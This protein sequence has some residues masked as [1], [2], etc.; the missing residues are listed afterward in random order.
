MGYAHAK[1][2]TVAH[3]PGGRHA[4]AARQARPRRPHRLS[5]CGHPFFTPR[6]FDAPLRRLAAT[7]RSLLRPWPPSGAFKRATQSIPS[8][9]PLLPASPD[10]GLRP[11]ARSEQ[12]IVVGNLVPALL[13]SL[14]HL[15]E[16]HLLGVGVARQLDV[17]RLERVECQVDVEVPLVV[18]AHRLR[19]EGYDQ[20]ARARAVG[21]P[22]AQQGPDA[23]D[24][25]PAS[26]AARG[27][28]LD[29]LGA[30]RVGGG[31]AE[32]LDA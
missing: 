8:L 25:Q 20:P 32:L 3:I 17:R 26:D 14:A 16:E 27:L 12:H 13:E 31:L 6:R 1:H 4:L 21:R 24:D 15:G 7:A 5:E 23:L 30:A 10:L 19:E 22:L 18:V 11:T 28:V 29:L 2:R 9:G